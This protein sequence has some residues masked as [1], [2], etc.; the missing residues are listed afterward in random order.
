MPKEERFQEIPADALKRFW[1]VWS[2]CMKQRESGDEYGSYLDLENSWTVKASDILNF[3]L[4][5]QRMNAERL[6][7]D[8]LTRAT[9]VL[10]GATGVL[11]L[12][13]LAL[14]VVT[15]VRG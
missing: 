8:R 9:Y 5:E 12:A 7:T 14:V 3:W 1:N 4:A 11:V 15:L 10:G 6:A 13:T 2:S